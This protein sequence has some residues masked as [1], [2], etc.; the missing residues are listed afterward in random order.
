MFDKKREIINGEECIAV[1]NAGFYSVADTFECGQ[2]FRA[3]K[4]K[5]E[6]G[7]TEYATVIGN[8]ILRVGQKNIGE[9]YVFDTDDEEFSLLV[10]PYLSLDRDYEAIRADIN[11]RTSSEW[12]RAASESAKGIAILRQDAWEALMS[13]IISQNN[14]IPRIK[15]IVRR[16]CAE[17]GECIAIKNKLKKC[18]FNKTS[19]TPCEEIC[20]KCGACYTFP[21]ADDILSNPEKMLLSNPGFRYKY[22][23]DAAQ[24]VSLG[25]VDFEY[26]KGQKSYEKTCEELKKIKGVGDKVA[27]CVALF[28]F[29]NLEAFPIDV[30]IKRAIDIYFDGELDY[31]GLGAYAG[32]AQQY[33]FHYIKNLI[34]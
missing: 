25:E 32:I 20:K 8:K 22:L 14:N 30:W 2:C 16:I 9:L 6:D 19:A 29:E 13:F 27:S 24:K 31:V 18:P 4:I 11:E 26:I 12:L 28:A 21:S 15:G 33:I 3:E 1:K 7:Y 17:Y 23:C 34:N 5:D 10:A